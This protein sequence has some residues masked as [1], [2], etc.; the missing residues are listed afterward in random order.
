MTAAPAPR[1]VSAPAV[2]E[3]ARGGG[4]RRFLDSPA[5]A[6]IA[7]VV[8][9]F[10]VV[11]LWEGGL[12]HGLFGIKPF[13]VPF[14]SAIVAGVAKH[15]E[16]I[17]LALTITLTAA[18]VGYLTGMT[19]GF[20][21]GSILVRFAPRLT[22][23]ILP[24]LSAT[25]SL[26]IVALAP[27]VALWT[28]P[29]ILLKVIVVTIMTTPTMV[30]YTVRG[31]RDVDPTALEL[32][33]SL[34]ATGGQV[35]RML[36]VRRALPFLF[37]ALKSAVVLAL[38]GTI[39]SEAVRG[40]EGLGFVIVH[41]MGSFEAARAWLALLAIAAVGIAWYLVIEVLERVVVPWEAASRRRS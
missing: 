5:P 37:T 27:L 20:T 9:L 40:F 23:R 24:V 10:V 18:F 11:G 34:E 41:S 14:P 35:Y 1:P 8:L 22:G 13:T 3:A 30:V 32:M 7:P 19:L 39:V 26:P 28:G 12:F 15:G 4:V 31:L 36:R 16:E 25:N 21:V 33:A 6:L 17:R 29:G 2:A 38:I